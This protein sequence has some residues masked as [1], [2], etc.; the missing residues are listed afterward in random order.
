MKLS[1]VDL[2]TFLE[3]MRHILLSIRTRHPT[4][5]LI[6]IT[7]A[8]CDNVAWMAWLR[9][10]GYPD[11]QGVLHIHDNSLT[12]R[13]AFALE[14]LCREMLVDCINAFDAFERAMRDGRTLADLLYDGVHPTPAGNQ[15]R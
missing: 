4:S 6:V 1:Q 7:P 10:L 15:V 11:D 2:S 13:F 12:K 5:G 8:Q 3:N 14:E 9:Q